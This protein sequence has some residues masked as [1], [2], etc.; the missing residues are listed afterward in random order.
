MSEQA[1]AGR[2]RR[3]LSRREPP[4]YG[5]GMS[6]AE[7]AGQASVV[8]RVFPQA[9]GRYV[10]L[11][12]LARGGMGAVFL[13]KYAGNAAAFERF[14]VI[15]TLQRQLTEDPEAVRR[16]FDEL[17]VVA[18]L[19]HR[20]ICSIF[21]AGAVDGRCYFAMDHVAGVDL[22]ALTERCRRNGAPLQPAL[23]VH[24]IGEVLEALGYAHRLID[25]VTGRPLGIVHRDI[26]PHNV[27][28]SFEGEVKLIDF[29]L[30]VSRL[31]TN[32]TQPD[33]VVGKVAYMSPE[34]AS[35]NPVDARAD[36]YSAAVVA[37]ELFTNSEFYADVPSQQAMWARAAMGGH[38]PPGFAALDPA[39]RAI[40]DRALQPSA[41]NRFDSCEDLRDALD[42][43]AARAGLHA[44]PR[45]L[46]ELARTH[47][48]AEADER[49]LLLASF[50]D[51]SAAPERAPATAV[52]PAALPTF[53]SPPLT[54]MALASPSPPRRPSALEAPTVLAIEEPRRRAPDSAPVVIGVEQVARMQEAPPHQRAVAGGGFEAALRAL[55]KASAG[56]TEV[57]V[58]APV[59]D[60]GEYRP[61]PPV[62]VIERGRSLRSPNERGR[63]A[64]V[65]VIALVVVLAACALIA[66]QRLGYVDFP[67]LASLVGRP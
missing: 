1:M 2:Y 55:P 30:V 31:K 60:T 35:G 62:P 11:H 40:L 63:S 36:Q 52:A 53:T 4:G 29:G 49:R 21:D 28:V 51:I 14:C 12:P 57:V 34:H 56:A 18:Q 33:V 54:P 26:S 47:F 19:N 17:K 9:F 6:A 25:G 58:R 45:A 46:R 61:V 16:F 42:G 44:T 23:I 50:S 10:L 65:G 13:A 39:L 20:N 15:K 3:K 38:R 24:I 8:T 41:D 7:E 22:Q 48:G 32:R 66:G 27:L 59:D 37:A 43:W 64:A 67:A 5:R